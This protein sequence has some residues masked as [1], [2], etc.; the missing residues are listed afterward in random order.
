MVGYLTMSDR[1]SSTAAAFFRFSIHILRIAY[2]YWFS[3]RMMI[4]RFVLSGGERRLVRCLQVSGPPTTRAR[5]LHTHH[6][7]QTWNIIV[8][9][10]PVFATFYGRPIWWFDED[11]DSVFYFTFLRSSFSSWIFLA[12]PT[13]IFFGKRRKNWRWSALRVWTDGRNGYVRAWG[14]VLSNVLFIFDG[15]DGGRRGEQVNN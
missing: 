14:Y 8:I 9:S 12:P 3:I 5:V 4:P 15:E 10:F 2:C 13:S 6:P 11:Y 7:Q 1:S